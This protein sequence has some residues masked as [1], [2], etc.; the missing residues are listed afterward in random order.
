[1]QASEETYDP[2]RPVKSFLPS[3]I[4]W[5]AL[6]YSQVMWTWILSNA[7]RSGGKHESL[8]S[9]T[10]SLIPWIAGFAWVAGMFLV[11][12]FFKSIRQKSPDQKGIQPRN[13][14]NQP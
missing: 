10:A 13:A 12:R 9:E 1:M 11:P 3:R 5:G 8:S 7:A 14:E 2:N 4:I 6:L